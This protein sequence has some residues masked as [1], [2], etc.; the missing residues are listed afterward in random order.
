MNEPPVEIQN[1]RLSALL[2]ELKQREVRLW[3]D[4]GRLRCDAPKGAVSAELQDQLRAHK[5]EIVALLR[6]GQ[7]GEEVEEWAEDVVL[8]DSIQPDGPATTGTSSRILLTGATG[9]L[10][11]YLLKEL[12]RQTDA[13]VSCLVRADNEDAARAR[14]PKSPASRVSIVLGD[15]SDDGLVLS[16][17]VDLIL[18]N[19]AHVHH[20]LPYASLRAANVFGTRRVIEMACR[21]SIPLH[22]VSS[23]SVLPPVTA[24]GDER[25]L[26]TDAI[27]EVPAPR[28]GYNLSKWVAERLVA[29]AAERGLP[30][31]VYRPGPISGD[32]VTGA[33]N[34]NDF[35][36]RLMQGYLQSGM[37]PD[38]E[39]PLDLLPVDYAA[40]AIVW[41][42]LNG[43]ATSEL[44]RYHLLHPN[45]ASSE[46]LFEA[47]QNAGLQIQRV[48]YD[49]WFQHLSEIARSGDTG[50]ALYPLVGLFSSRAGAPVP[51]E[52]ERPPI[53]YDTSVTDAALRDA[54]LGLP[55]LNAELFATYLKA[56]RNE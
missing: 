7:R 54:P 15:L 8:S 9:F 43:S 17:D 3:L 1:Q 20:G 27:E 31:T 45:S 32:S 37:A 6:S 47:C 13:Q 10:G 16:E 42:A 56:M 48:P 11:G 51:A 46:L 14:L 38:G 25:F 52:G 21:R 53:P 2:A 41:L 55:E 22:F 26:E 28:G 23:L 29:Q 39:M 24:G 50:H 40:K 12:L 5:E 33:F 34:E 4:E 19:G 18:H 35:L 44:R 30:V 49:E 36:Y